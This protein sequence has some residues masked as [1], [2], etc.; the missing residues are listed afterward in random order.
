[1]PLNLNSPKYCNLAERSNFS[2][3]FADIPAHAYQLYLTLIS[4]SKTGNSQ[5]QRVL[6]QQMPHAAEAQ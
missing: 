1:M 2:P 6:C 5:Y 3:D 4:F